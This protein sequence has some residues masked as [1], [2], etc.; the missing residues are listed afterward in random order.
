MNANYANKTNKSNEDFPSIL[1]DD[2][3]KYSNIKILDQK[4]IQYKDSPFES[5]SASRK[6]VDIDK[7]SSF[8]QKNQNDTNSEFSEDMSEKVNKNRK[9][10]EMINYI[11]EPIYNTNKNYKKLKTQ[12]NVQTKLNFK[13][14]LNKN[15]QIMNSQNENQIIQE[16]Q[17]NINHPINQNYPQQ[18]IPDE[19]YPINYNQIPQQQN[20]DQPPQQYQQNDNINNNYNNNINDKVFQIISM[21]H[22]ALHVGET[23]TEKA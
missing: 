16:N 19:N 4:P 21:I 8:K 11:S 7:G 13:N 22:K 1:P 10:N 3:E 12:P 18:I 17:P 23:E 5:R 15:N 14:N 2:E 9:L 6:N 20:Y